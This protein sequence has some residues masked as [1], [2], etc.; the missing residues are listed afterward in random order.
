MVR[1]RPTH[2]EFLI[3]YSGF[4]DRDKN[5]AVNAVGAIAR[6][7]PWLAKAVQIAFVAVLSYFVLTLAA[8]SAKK[9]SL[10]LLNI[11]TRLMS[12][13][14]AEIGVQFI[15]TALKLG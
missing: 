1:R 13:L 11:I 12:L 6:A 2:R 7:V 10:T 15:L 9:L 3:C 8:D 4:R 5:A 14:L